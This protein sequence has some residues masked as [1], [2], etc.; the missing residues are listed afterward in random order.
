[1]ARGPMPMSWRKK[2]SEGQFKAHRR[3]KRLKAQRSAKRRK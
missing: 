2:I 1:M 3:K